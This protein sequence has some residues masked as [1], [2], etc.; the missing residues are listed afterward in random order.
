MNGRRAMVLGGGGSCGAY[1]LGVWEA[2]SENGREFDGFFGTSIGAINAALMAQGDI[3]LARQLWGNISVDQVM[4]DG[5]NLEFDISA[6]LG[7]RRELLA[8]LKRYARN[9]GADI[10]PLV[11]LCRRVVDEERIRKSGKALGL[12]AVRFP[13]LTPVY[14][15]LEQIPRGVLVDYLM[16]S[17]ACFP[18][19]PMWQMGGDTY[20]DGGY[21]DNLPIDMALLAGAEEI[22]AVELHRKPCHPLAAR[23]PYVTHIRP[24][25]PLGGI[26]VFEQ[27]VI[28]RN[29]RLGYLDAMKA[30]GQLRG[31]RYAFL[32]AGGG[33]LEAARRFA[34][35]TARAEAGASGHADHPVSRA[36]L[37]E[38]GRESLT[39]EEMLLR[40]CELCAQLLGLEPTGVYQEG[41]L[42]RRMRAQTEE[43]LPAVEAAQPFGFLARCTSDQRVAA[44]ACLKR[45]VTERSAFTPHELREMCARP[46]ELA[47]AFYLAAR[48]QTES[49][50]EM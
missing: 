39:Y 15:R 32:P 30:L 42:Y 1:E 41:E 40:G 5:I 38:T 6:L 10:T 11:N 19:F 49:G 45:L 13:A 12:V 23:Q 24:S 2:F 34:M 4:S 35:L 3:D 27:T 44:V 25:W 29:R 18:A 33:S 28:Q 9:R 26:L 22:T 17:A 47:A 50:H 37:E 48:E 16:A 36:L 14:A 31:L 20:I 7:Q 46:R 43:Q 21:C 8:F